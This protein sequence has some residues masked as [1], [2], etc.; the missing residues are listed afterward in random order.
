MLAVEI[1]VGAAW[2]SGD[3]GGGVWSDGSDGGA[4]TTIDKAGATTRD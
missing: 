1:G 2:S 4:G 3:D